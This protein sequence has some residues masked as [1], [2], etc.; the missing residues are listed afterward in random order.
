[1]RP[2]IKQVK[3]YLINLQLANLLNCNFTLINLPPF[4]GQTTCGKISDKTTENLKI[5]GYYKY[6]R[7]INLTKEE[8]FTSTGNISLPI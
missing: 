4:Y 2:H 3:L 7:G 8:Y 6:Q 5:K 1:M